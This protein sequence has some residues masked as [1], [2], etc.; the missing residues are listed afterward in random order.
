MR[1]TRLLGG[2]LAGLLLGTGCA[3]SHANPAPTESAPD[4]SY[5]ARLDRARLGLRGPERDATLADLEKLT[6][7]LES[8]LEKSPQDA[9]LH[10]LLARAAFTLR[11]TE[12]AREEAERALALAP[13]LA[14]PYYIKAFL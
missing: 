3:A 1:R 11:R 8:R 12:K 5:E 7:E 10:A 9:R 14:E 13:E 6:R 2:L 4:T